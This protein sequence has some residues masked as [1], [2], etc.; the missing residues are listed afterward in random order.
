MIFEAK[1]FSSYMLIMASPL[2]TPSNPA[3]DTSLVNQFLQGWPSYPTS[4]Q[5][6][7][8]VGIYKVETLEA[9]TLWDPTNHAMKLFFDDANNSI[10]LGLGANLSTLQLSSGSGTAVTLNATSQTGSPS[11][12]SL[13]SG[14]ASKSVS[15]TT[16]AQRTGL[17][18]SATNFQFGSSAPNAS[19]TASI[20]FD[21]TSATISTG[22][23]GSQQLNILASNIFAS[24][25]VFNANADVQ[26]KGAYAIQKTSNSLAFAQYLSS[27][28]AQTVS[29]GGIGGGAQDSNTVATFQTSALTGPKAWLNGSS[30]YFS[31]SKVGMNWSSP[32]VAE[33]TVELDVNG[34][35]YARNSVQTSNVFNVASSNTMTIGWNVNQLGQTD[36]KKIVLQADSI[37]MVGDI[38]MMNKT[39]LR[40]EDTMIYLG[41]IPGETTINGVV[42]ASNAAPPGTYSDTHYDGSGIVLWNL[43]DGYQAF[44]SAPGLP[45]ADVP[46]Y[47][48]YQ[49]SLRWYKRGG[50][51]DTTNAGSYIPAWN[52]SSWEVSGGNMT[53]RAG[54]GHSSYMFAIDYTDDSLKL[55][56]VSATSIQ[57]VAN[58]NSLVAM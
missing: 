30:Q 52:R 47:A 4:S 19:G 49:Q 31:G 38:N 44:A 56:K 35:I 45:P 24:A 6:T 50:V 43:P 58:F 1:L 12:I 53:L 14:D 27:S 29:I 46:A 51:F 11:T 13:Q 7:G 25:A 8:P 48:D 34:T 10:D 32:P 9:S 57:E 21:T 3:T 41:T 54:T 20:S 42:D 23:A 22:T 39:D 36:L 5:P 2:A 26:V 33:P 15:V 55:Y 16:T 37:E 18:S 28:D 17:V 40:V